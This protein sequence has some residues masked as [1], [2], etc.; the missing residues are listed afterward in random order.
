[1]ANLNPFFDTLIY[2]DFTSSDVAGT[3]GKWNRIGGY[4]VPVQQKMVVGYGSLSAQNQAV[5]R[6]YVNLQDATPAAIAGKIR[7]IVTNQAETTMKQVVAVRSSVAALGASDRRLRYPLPRS[8]WVLDENDVVALEFD[9]DSAA[10]ASAANCS[11]EI[12]VTR[13][14]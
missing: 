14:A 7:V 6:L 1:M 11:A 5:G 12:D 9:P 10:T 8:L 13:Y 4:S 3:A 2:S